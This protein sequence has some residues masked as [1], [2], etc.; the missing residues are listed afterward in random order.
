MHDRLVSCI[1]PVWNGEK[2]L[3]HALDS[4]FAQSH[5]AVDV[6]VV[7]DGS[8]DATCSICEQHAGTIRV[9]SQ[10][11]AGPS[12]AR[13]TGIEHAKGDFVAFLDYDDLWTPEKLAKQLAVF[14]SHP[15]IGACVGYVQEFED[16]DDG[17]VK[18]RG[19]PIVGYT[20][21][22]AM[23]SREALQTVGPFN[24]AIEHA[25]SADW[26]L[27]ARNAGIRDMLLPDVLLNR[28]CHANNRSQLRNNNTRQE[29]LNLLRANVAR[30]RASKA[31]SGQ[32]DD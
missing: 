30:H 6:I 26:F 32:R 31:P 28:R 19:D 29:F 17:S 21:G 27:R 12:V 11:N 16:K 1:L 18:L 3:V 2:Y 14:A 20:T 7:D 9:V 25:D 5:K 24:T 23:L 22:T 13:N 15:E 8:T 4:I 10:A